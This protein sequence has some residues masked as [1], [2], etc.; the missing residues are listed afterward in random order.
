MDLLRGVA[1]LSVLY[2]HGHYQLLRSSGIPLIK[3]LKSIDGVDL[4][5]VLSGFLIGGIIIRKFEN[6]RISPASLLQFWKFRWFRTLPNYYFVLAVTLPVT[7]WLRGD[8]MG[9]TPKYLFFLQNLAWI[10]PPFMPVAWSL[11]VEEWFYLLFPIM[12]AGIS[13][14]LP[15]LSFRMRFLLA[16]LLMAATAFASRFLTLSSFPGGF[17]MLEGMSGRYERERI[18]GVVLNRLDAIPFGVVGAYA[19][20]YHARIWRMIRWPSLALGAYVHLFQSSFGALIPKSMQL[21][22]YHHSPLLAFLLALPFASTWKSAPGWLSRP[23]T[24]VSIISYSIYLIHYDIVIM[25]TKRLFGSNLQAPMALASFAFYVSVTLV[26]SM[27]LYRFYEK[28][29]TDLR[30][31]SVRGRLG[32]FWQRNFASGSSTDG[33]D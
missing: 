13:A 23:I 22:F 6:E 15:V 19:A 21:M 2:F 31:G 14:A 10:H 4:F 18:Y 16:V 24:T 26:L 30:N 5:F 12:L 9:F 32:R 28:P 8:S 17:D 27:L 1:V 20:H 11:A 3:V 7:I 29:M 33:R 25:F